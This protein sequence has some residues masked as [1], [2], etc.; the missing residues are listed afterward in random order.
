MLLQQKIWT[1]ITITCEKNLNL[2]VQLCNTAIFKKGV[3][4]MEISLYSKV[5]DQIKLKEN[6]NSFEKELKSFL[7][8]HC[9]YSVD[10]F[11]PF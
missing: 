1:S 10:E 7:L 9:F 6:F 2:H 4:N 8:K 11:M 3:I 5:S